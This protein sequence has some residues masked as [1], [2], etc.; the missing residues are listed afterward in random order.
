MKKFAQKFKNFPKFL[1]L[2]LKMFVFE[3]LR[4]FYTVHF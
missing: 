3:N 1:V 4:K 2:N